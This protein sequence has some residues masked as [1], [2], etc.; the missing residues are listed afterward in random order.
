MTTGPILGKLLLYSL[1]LA[2]TGVLQV[3]FNAADIIVIGQ[4]A[5]DGALAAVGACSALVPLLVNFFIGLSI[6]VKIALSHALGAK[7]D[8]E[9]SEHVHN[10]MATALICGIL[11]LILGQ[12][13][14]GPMLRLMGTPEEI[15]DAAAMY[16]R[17]YFC[18]SP[19]FL[20]Y[21]YGAAIIR[22]SGDTRSPL[23]YLSFSG[24]LNV[25]LNLFFILVLGW[26]DNIVL[27]A[28]GVAIATAVS[29]YSSAILIVGHL[30]RTKSV[31]RLSLRRIRIHKDKF[32]RIL[33]L[34]IPA[35]IQSSL[36]SISNV[37]IQSNINAFGP[38]AIAGN[39]AA[40]SIE[41]FGHTALDAFNQAALTFIGQNKGAG[42]YYRFKRIY[43]TSTIAVCATAF[44]ISAI[45]LALS[46]P[47]LS[48]YIAE[49][50]SGTEFALV[51]MQ[52]L[53][54]LLFTG[55]MMSV[56]GG[57]VRGFGKSVTAMINAVIGICGLRLLWIYVIYPFLCNGEATHDIGCLYLSYPFTWIMTTILQ[58]I[59][60]I[61]YLRKEKKAHPDFFRRS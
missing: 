18:G 34:G 2:L 61:L 30:F 23:L 3:C 57:S 47:L 26:R 22:T 31:L 49:G 24:V 41:N 12:T 8:K 17:I 45:I 20:V 32:F 55:G 37:L 35:G 25:I 39:T 28:A 50:T 6:G 60:F 33:A 13:L 51:R 14:S 10:A 56:A 15:V 54:P 1:P 53:I 48:F 43:I 7:E 4:F 9:A 38:A 27:A 21:N 36:F 11:V 59:F 46:K 44:I 52:I 58:V 29:H 42:K 16:M 5:A 19:A 40:S